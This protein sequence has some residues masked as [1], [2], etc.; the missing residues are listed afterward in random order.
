MVNK[1]IKFSEDVQL[2]IH[3][4]RVSL[5]QASCWVTESWLLKLLLLIDRNWC[6]GVSIKHQT[7]LWLIDQ[8]ENNSGQ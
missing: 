8:D 5:E 2:I 6:Q 1:M 4:L 7:A 3:Q